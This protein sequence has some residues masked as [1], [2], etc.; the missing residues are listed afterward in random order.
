MR[1]ADPLMKAFV[2]FRADDTGLRQDAQAKV[3]TATEGLGAKVKVE[4]DQ[5]RLDRQRTELQAKLKA[6]GGQAATIR[7]SLKVDDK[8]GLAKVAAWQAKLAAL[9][10]RVVSARFKLDGVAAAE[11]QILGLDAAMDRAGNSAGSLGV[12]SGGAARGLSGLTTAALAFGPAIIPAVA[13]ASAGMIGFGGIIAGTGATLGLFGA[14]AATHYKQMA[15]ELKKVEAAN[16]AANKAGAS[17]AVIA[18]AKAMT[19]AFQKDYGALAAAQERMQGAWKKFTSQPVINTIL[20]KGLN[21]IADIIPKLQPLFDAGAAAATRFLT[22]I[23]GWVKSGG[24][25]NAVSLL[26]DLGRAVGPHIEAT[27]RNLASIAASLAP[28][29]FDL[30]VKVAAGMARMTGAMASWAGNRGVDAMNSFMAY[31]RQNGAAVAGALAALA[32]AAVN[33]ARAL[34]PL[35]PVSLAVATAI[36][37]LVAVM[38]PQV[39]TALAVA[40]LGYSA[41]AKAGALYTHV[42]GAEGVAWAA[43]AA[44]IKGAT[45]AWTAAQWLLNV[46]LTANP[47]GLVIVAL[48]ALAAGIYLAW[49]RSAAFRDVLIGLWGIVKSV[50]ASIAGAFVTAIAAITGAFRQVTGFASSVASTIAAPFINAFNSIKTFV[51]ASFDKWWASN[52]EAIKAIW[53]AVWAAVSAVFHAWW[54]PLAA[55]AKAGWA[56]LTEVFRVGAAVITVVWRA[57]W[58]VISAIGLSVWSAVT[59]AARAAWAV[60]TATAALGWAVI[61]AVFRVGA[62]AVTA[63]W[64]VLWAVVIATA[65]VAWAAIRTL[66]KISWDIIVGIFTVAVNLLTGR[67]GAAWQAIKNTGVQVWN[68]ISSFFKTAWSAY[69][70][71]FT[72]VGRNIVS[73]WTTTWN[74]VKSVG[75]AAWRWIGTVV[76]GP[77][78][79]MFTQTVGSWFNTAVNAIRTAWRNIQDAVKN[80]VKFVVNVV[81]GGL[82][83]AFNTITGALGLPLKIHVPKM[84]TGGPVRDGTG[85]TADDVLVRVSRNETIVSA[86]HSRVL[87]PVFGAVGVPGYAAGGIPNPIGIVQK[88]AG[89]LA[90]TI[91][92]KTNVGDVIDLVQIAKGLGGFVSKGTGGAAGI[93]KDVLT[94]IPKKILAGMLDWFTAHANAGGAEIVNYAMQFLGKIPYVWGGTSLSSAGADC[95]GFTQSVYGHFG[96]GAPRTSEAQGSWVTRGPPQP[97]GLAFYHSPGGGPDPGHVA[98][99]R[100]P[101]SVISQGGGMGPRVESLHVLPL[102]WTGVPPGGLLK[103]TGAAGVPAGVSGASVAAEQAYAFGLFPGYGWGPGQRQPL[104]S[105]WNQESNWNPWAVNPSSGAYGIPQALGH[106]HPYALGDWVHQILWG[107]NYIQGR[108][109]SPAAAWGHEVAS[110][111]YAGGTSSAAPGLAVVGERGPELVRFR[112]GE[113][114]IPGY[115][116]GGFIGGNLGQQGSSYL[117]AWQ[118]RHGG[119]FGAAWAPVVLNQQIAAMTAAISRAITLSK[120]G[121]LSAAQHKHWAYVAADEKKRL[122]TLNH[123]LDVERKWRTALTTSDNQLNTWIKA[124]GNTPSLRKNVTSWKAQLARQ[125]TAITGISKM[126]G[127]SDAWLKAHP[128]PPAANAT[129]K[130]TYGGDVAN[131]LGAVLAS[132]LG[133]FTGTAT[134]MD[135]G[136]WAPPGLSH[137]WNGTGRPEPVGGGGAVQLEVR[138]GGSE[139]DQFMAKMIKKYVKVAGGGDVQRAYGAR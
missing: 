128:P 123:E 54:D 67:W 108:Y 58:T 68:A 139:F 35:A 72:T 135:N 116:A 30:G 133:P 115:A 113:Q 69:S 98:I 9:D 11:A 12:S 26:A 59:A 45:L 64:N 81:L 104:V 71:L 102:L 121:G 87:A 134:V 99:V 117:K 73:S 120:A 10:K 5:T 14:A 132:A 63:I 27:L 83:G 79:T 131:N 18:N 94:A 82:A 101:S 31:L 112:G 16:L 55:A 106:G 137:I 95:S 29:F 2:Q 84:A 76:L 19:A 126:L 97:G 41:A 39:I 109:G 20:A 129:I 92:G 77:M 52:G 24:L 32:G 56:V 111:W 122:A 103:N 110:N 136:G 48:A 47:I 21:L 40:F 3:K 25:G 78:R 100:D 57:A 23:Q 6:L 61:T 50:A 88:V 15:A 130:H 89:A 51:T 93:M 74:S 91:G 107:L 34:T 43:K 13:V 44:I 28:L 1:V 37:R 86:A 38:P 53:R 90:G 114:V 17:P 46:A 4:L 119:G 7:A 124:A 96:I 66:L 105:L 70:G 49:T 85:E 22:A 33:I 62:G 42:F 127:Y 80:P 138:G 65:R 125:K 8:E 60:L 118:T 75:Q 36:A